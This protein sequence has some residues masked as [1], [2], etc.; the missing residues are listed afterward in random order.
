MLISPS[1]LIFNRAYKR[2]WSQKFDLFFDTLLWSA[3]A[4]FAGITTLHLYSNRTNY[5]IG[6]HIDIA[7]WVLTPLI[8]GRAIYLAHT[9][10]AS[11]EDLSDFPLLN[12]YQVIFPRMA[13][14]LK[15]CIIKLLPIYAILLISRVYLIEH[16]WPVNLNWINS[17]FLGIDLRKYFELIFDQSYW[18]YEQAL[19]SSEYT[20]FIQVSGKNLPTMMFVGSFLLPTVWGFIVGSLFK[21][22]TNLFFIMFP[23][24]LIIPA[25][26]YFTTHNIAISPYSELMSTYSQYEYEN[27]VYKVIISVL[28]FEGLYGIVLSMVLL[29]YTVLAWKKRGA[30]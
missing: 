19:R 13:A 11:D 30:V 14:V 17:Q 8:I 28:T 9:S 25:M 7:F 29:P 23:V 6:S 1:E 15:T 4:F 22:K 3:A 24:Y 16:H 12:P 5:Q 18:A 21:N 27:L 2:I 20:G 10:K 26:L